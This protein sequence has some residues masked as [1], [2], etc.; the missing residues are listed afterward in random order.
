MRQAAPASGPMSRNRTSTPDH[1]MIALPTSSAIHP[2]RSAPDRAIIRTARR[3]AKGARRS[4]K[5]V[6]RHAV[7]SF[8][9]SCI[10]RPSPDSAT[11]KL[12]RGKSANAIRLCRAMPA[13]PRQECE[14]TRS[15]G[16]GPSARCASGGPA[17]ASA[18]FGKRRSCEHERPP[19]RSRQR[20]ARIELCRRTPTRI[21]GGRLS[22]A[23]ASGDADGRGA[24][25]HARGQHFLHLPRR[26]PERL[27]QRLRAFRR[28]AR[29]DAPKPCDEFEI[30][31]RVELAIELRLVRQP[32]DD[33]LGRD[34]LAARVDPKNV[35]FAEMIFTMDKVYI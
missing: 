3:S 33:P 25:A 8:P 17:G 12:A 34:R 16:V 1:A 18:R 32:G 7:S 6:S 26:A 15:R 13:K 31:E 27:Q 22:V 24:F 10:A 11:R 35:D 14:A 2:F 9:P 20:R 5:T 4:R 21:Y 28:A 29:L 23:I 19:S 30:F